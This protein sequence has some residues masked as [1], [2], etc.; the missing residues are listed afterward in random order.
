MLAIVN[1]GNVGVYLRESNVFI[2]ILNFFFFCFVVFWDKK[3][4]IITHYLP[5]LELI[6]RLRI[7]YS[8]SFF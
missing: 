3:F 7:L 2:D 5:T 4:D 1:K 6:Q 8:F